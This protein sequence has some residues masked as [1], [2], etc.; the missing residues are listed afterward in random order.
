MDSEG[1]PGL[2]VSIFR[3]TDQVRGGPAL[4]FTHVGGM[5]FGDRFVG[6]STIIPWVE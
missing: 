3:R 4:F 6:V 2:V 1:A 5:V